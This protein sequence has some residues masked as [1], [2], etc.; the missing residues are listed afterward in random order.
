MISLGQMNR[1]LVQEKTEDGWQLTDE[2]GEQS[3][4]LPSEDAPEAL[5]CGDS[6]TVFVYQGSEQELLATTARPQIMVGQLALLKAKHQ[7]PYGTFVD[8]GLRKDLLVPRREQREPM[9]PGQKYLVYAYLDDQGR[10]AA[11]A[12]YRKFIDQD[13][14][15]FRDGDEVHLTV[16]EATPLG[17]NVIVDYQFSALLYEDQV[18]RPVKLGDQLRGYVRQVREDGLLDVSTQKPGYGKVEELTDKI[19]KQLELAGG[20]LN[21]SDKSDPRIIQREFHCSKKAFKQA[22]GALKKQGLIDIFPTSIRR[23]SQ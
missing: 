22:L 21:I 16:T 20:E 13:R 10:I 11:S 8:W 1:T 12:K 7:T 15:I 5:N 23:L 14:H 3:L 19:M 17:Y 18:F 2:S 4:L 6:L 9:E